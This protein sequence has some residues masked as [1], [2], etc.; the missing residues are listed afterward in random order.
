MQ[1]RAECG[2]YGRYSANASGN[3]VSD[4]FAKRKAS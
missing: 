1:S 2:G 4:L 3:D